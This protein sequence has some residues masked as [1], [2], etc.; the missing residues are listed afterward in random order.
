M[1]KFFILSCLGLSSLFGDVISVLPYGGKI[2]YGSDYQSSYKDYATL[3]GVHA[4]IGNL[5]YLLEVDYSQYTATYKDPTQEQLKQ[6]DIAVA[7]G[8]YFP[9]WM[10][11]FGMHY[12]S[13][14]DEQLGDGIVGILGVGGYSFYGYDKFSYGMNGYLS[15][16]KDGHSNT[17][18]TTVDPTKTIIIT[19]LSPYVSY[20]KSINKDWGNL[21]HLQLD[22]EYASEYDKKSYYS[23]AISDTIYYKKAFINVKYYNGEMRTGV[24]DNG[25]T[26]Y[27]TLDL[28]KNGYSA[29]VGISLDALTLAFGYVSNTYREYDPNRV[30]ITKDNTNSLYFTTISI[31]F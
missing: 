22:A 28:V 7:Y 31:G 4:S 11:R 17:Q 13:T 23:F 20:Y 5:G 2:D 1:K 8:K 21:I 19:Q 12:I 6:D 3:Y 9:S 25:F 10:F 16:Y 24:K 27:N 18:N 30:V 15:Y 14:T 26:V 29:K